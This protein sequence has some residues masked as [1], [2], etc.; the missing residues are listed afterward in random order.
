MVKPANRLPVEDIPHQVGIA[1]VRQNMIDNCSLFDLSDGSAANA[2]RVIALESSCSLLPSAVIATLLGAATTAVTFGARLLPG[3][4]ALG[5]KR[6]W[7]DRHQVLSFIRHNLREELMA[8]D[9][10][11]R[12][13]P[14]RDRIN[15]HEDY[16]RN[17]WKKALH[18]S[19]QQ[20]SA[21]VKKVGPMVKNVKQY[22]K[23]KD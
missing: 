1:L 3:A 2:T 18:V 23:S 17:Y 22:L 11:K 6:W 8:D 19:G 14:D 20:L 15:V 21:A 9:R 10:T 7:T 4:L 16:E 5:P 13:K 12:G